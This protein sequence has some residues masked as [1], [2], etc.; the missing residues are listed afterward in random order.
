M[1]G[2]FKLDGIRIVRC[3]GVSTAKQTCR[4]VV[5]V[6]DVQPVNRIEDA[7]C[8]VVNTSGT[9]I[10]KE[11]IAV[12]TI[13]IGDLLTINQDCKVIIIAACF[14]TAICHHQHRGSVNGCISCRPALVLSLG[15]KGG[16][17]DDCTPQFMD[18]Q[19]VYFFAWYVT[20]ASRGRLRSDSGAP[21][22]SPST[23][24]VLS[25]GSRGIAAGDQGLRPV[26]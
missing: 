5:A 7:G 1:A 4:C 9:T 24:M 19:M 18:R 2:L 17:K 20:N 16:N 15:F 11:A 8:G 13:D 23:K 6:A 12:I 22:S 26:E 10:P 3:A 25:S 21:G 14:K